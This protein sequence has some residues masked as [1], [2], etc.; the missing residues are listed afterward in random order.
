L[1]AVW[2]PGT[3]YSRSIVLELLQSIHSP[4]AQYIGMA[5]GVLGVLY[6]GLLVGERAIRVLTRLDEYRANRPSG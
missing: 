1:S 5:Y 6:A 4:L 2:L 3:T